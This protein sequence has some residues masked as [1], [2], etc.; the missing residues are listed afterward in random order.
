MAYKYKIRNFNYNSVTF[1]LSLIF[2]NRVFILV[3]VF[4]N[5]FPRLKFKN[6]T[7][8][9]RSNNMIYLTRV[10]KDTLQRSKGIRLAIY[11]G[12]GS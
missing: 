11:Q 1:T 5:S 6:I 3:I 7:I 8:I 9:Q 10:K 4:S 2:W 12:E